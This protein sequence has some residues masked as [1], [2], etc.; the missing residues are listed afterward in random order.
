[1]NYKEKDTL[2]ELKKIGIHRKSNNM[3]GVLNV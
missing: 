3:L 2:E 1:M